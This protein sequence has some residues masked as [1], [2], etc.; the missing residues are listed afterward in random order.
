MAEIADKIS[1]QIEQSERS[2]LNNLIAV[3]VAI[4]ASLMAIYN[5]K[6]NNIVQAMSQAQAHNIDSWSYYQ[7]KSTKQ[8]LVENYLSQLQLQ[9]LMN[10]SNSATEKTIE[11]QISES[12]KRIE[13]Y[14]QEKAQIKS[15][16]EGFQKE[17]DALNLHDDQFDL[18]E[19]LISLSLSIFGITALTQ[20][21]PLFYFGTLLS[22]LGIFFG[23]A[24]FLGWS[25]HPEW[26]TKI[27][28]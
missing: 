18:A 28:G 15:Q 21:K 24:G 14:E 25:V 7:A 19:A 26:L 16:A 8:N 11:E 2:Q 6:D 23:L 12:K 3:I 5:I 27:L 22:G 17:Y 20:K 13:K 4:S 10:K 9:A 1:E